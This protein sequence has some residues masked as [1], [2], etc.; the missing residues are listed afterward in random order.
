MVNE[1][2]KDGGATLSMSGVVRGALTSVF[3]AW[4]NLSGTEMRGKLSGHLMQGT[5]G[6]S[7][8]T[9]HSS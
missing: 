2:S 6:S 8:V 4:A 5:A 1:C 3:G 9:G 7:Q